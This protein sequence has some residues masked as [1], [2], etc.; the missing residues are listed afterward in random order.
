MNSLGLIILAEA[1]QPQWMWMSYGAHSETQVF[2]ICTMYC[3]IPDVDSLLCEMLMSFFVQEPDDEDQ[4]HSKG[5]QK[6]NFY[7]SLIRY[8]A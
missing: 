8:K 7:L 5:N 6:E 1:N 2:T 3:G 4:R